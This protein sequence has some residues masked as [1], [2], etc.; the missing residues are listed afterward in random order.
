MGGAGVSV[1]GADVDRL[2]RL[3]GSPDPGRGSGPGVVVEEV[4]K[5]GRVFAPG[6]P[7]R[8][9]RWR[10]PPPADRRRAG[11]RGRGRGTASRR[12]ARLTPSLGRSLRRPDAA[13]ARR[14]LRPAGPDRG[15]RGR[16]CTVAQI[17]TSG[18]L[19]AEEGNSGRRSCCPF[20]RLRQSIHLLRHRLFE[21]LCLV[22]REER[23]MRWMGGGTS[24]AVCA[25]IGLA[26]GRW[27]LSVGAVGG[28]VVLVEH[29][30]RVALARLGVS[31]DDEPGLPPDKAL[32][33]GAPSPARTPPSP[34]APGG[35]ATA[36]SGGVR[37]QPRRRALIAARIASTATSFGDAGGAELGPRRRHGDRDRG[38]SEQACSCCFRP[39]AC[40]A[41]SHC[42]RVVGVRAFN[43][44]R[45]HR[46]R[47]ARLREPRVR[48]A[49]RW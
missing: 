23:T 19:G 28:L 38:F 17:R 31:V 43:R 37:R 22:S 39:A 18:R 45:T 16:A 4:P 1:D 3:A 21:T 42:W 46:R 10:R 5:A 48:S 13:P 41:S 47:L 24:V 29:G 25:A 44:Y 15:R 6:Y 11:P 2:T 9:W 30:T 7:V 35:A 36:T 12:Q 27:L 33:P 14:L 8:I 49:S 26:T 32:V 20:R 40:S 34:A